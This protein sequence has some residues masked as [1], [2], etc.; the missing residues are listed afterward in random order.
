[1]DARRVAAALVAGGAVML[2]L[3]RRARASTMATETVARE[4]ADPPAPAPGPGGVRVNERLALELYPERGVG[5]RVV[6]YGPA[7]LRA[8]AEKGAVNAD[9]AAALFGFI[10]RESGWYLNAHGD[11]GLEDTACGSSYGLLQFRRCVVESFGSTVADI[12]PFAGDTPTPGETALALRET[13]KVAEGFLRQKRQWMAGRTLQQVARSYRTWQDQARELR[14]SWWR[15]PGRSY[16]SL[17]A[18]E[19]EKV[20][21]A[22]PEVEKMRRVLGLPV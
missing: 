22:I 5:Q 1:M 16:Q 10:V 3:R 9:E 19:R 11:L 18:E 14:T 6:R 7:L 2:L 21:R 13:A 4:T 17:S 12:Y 20:E 8:W 15:G